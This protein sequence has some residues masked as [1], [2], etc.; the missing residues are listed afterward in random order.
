MLTYTD[1]E[2]NRIIRSRWEELIRD[3]SYCLVALDRV[4]PD[5]NVATRWTG[6]SDS[7]IDRRPF[8]YVTAVWRGQPFGSDAIVDSMTV[9]ETEE[10]ALRV[11]ER[12]VHRALAGRA[13][14]TVPATAPR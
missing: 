6:I 7:E 10:E 8:P 1:R 3:E 12:T 2:G 14:L 9:T 13:L 5:V 11:H 4:A